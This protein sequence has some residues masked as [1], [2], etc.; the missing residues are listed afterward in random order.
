MGIMGSSRGIKL[1][2]QNRNNPPRPQL[3]LK[4]K[5]YKKLL[6]ERV[7]RIVRIIS[8]LYLY[9]NFE[10]KRGV[11]LYKTYYTV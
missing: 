9:K 2:W 11:G 8:V 5:V 6:Q 10:L 4:D 7:Y 3:Q 1:S